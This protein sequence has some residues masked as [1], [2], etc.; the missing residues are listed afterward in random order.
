MDKLAKPTG[1]A[2]TTAWLLL[3]ILTAGSEVLDPSAIVVNL[4]VAVIFLGVLLLF[5]ER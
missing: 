4:V 3:S 5:S 2:A 1:L